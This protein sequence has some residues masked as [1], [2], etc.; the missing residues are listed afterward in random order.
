ML[1]NVES[2]IPERDGGNTYQNVYTLMLVQITR[3][4]SGLPD[5]RDLKARQI[6]FF[7]DQ[8]KPELRGSDGR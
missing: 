3:E 1:G 2:P 5:I 4:Y 7:Y 6:K 8:L